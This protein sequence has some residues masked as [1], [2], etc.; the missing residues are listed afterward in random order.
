MDNNQQQPPAGIGHNEP[1]EPPKLADTQEALDIAAYV[2][3]CTAGEG[4]L[5]AIFAEAIKDGDDINDDKAKVKALE[6]KAKIADIRK[7]ADKI[8]AEA[9]D[10]FARQA[11]LAQDAFN[12]LKAKADAAESMLGKKVLDYQGRLNQQKR[13]QEEAAAAKARE[14]AE[15]LAAQAEADR[16]AAED[17][18]RKAAESTDTAQR[19]EANRTADALEEQKRNADAEAARQATQAVIHNAEAAVDDKAKGTR[20]IL[21]GFNVVDISKIPDS[22]F[23]L[24]VRLVNQDL[25]EKKTIAGIEPIFEERIVS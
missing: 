4:K 25:R 1:P 12:G 15:R 3:R 21:T 7:L 23:V 2:A 20:R 16:K 14:E 5:D 18:R 8:R 10:P 22:Y 11:K 24:D 6:A 13:E 17:L 19:D 9:K